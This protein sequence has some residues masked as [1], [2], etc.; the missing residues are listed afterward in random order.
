MVAWSG[1]QDSPHA[2]STDGLTVC[3]LLRLLFDGLMVCMAHDTESLMACVS[4]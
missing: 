3:L 1:C 2:Q 4:L